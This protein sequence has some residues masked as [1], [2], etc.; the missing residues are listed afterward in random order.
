MVTPREM[1]RWSE[2]CVLVVVELS[3][4]VLDPLGW[5]EMDVGVKAVVVKA[6]VVN[7]EERVEW[8]EERRSGAGEGRGI[9]NA[10]L[11][12]ARL[13]TVGKEVDWL[14]AGSDIVSCGVM[15]LLGGSDIDGC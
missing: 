13:C 8:N 12:A 6:V 4:Y 3:E 7:G 15:D 9:V 10:F 1:S 2:L 14:L 11:A 5:R